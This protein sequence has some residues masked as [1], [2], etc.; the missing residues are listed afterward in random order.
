VNLTVS[1]SSPLINLAR[2]QR[3]DLLRRF[4]GEVIIPS[5]VYE[6]VVT[7]GSDRDGAKDVRAA[8]WIQ[9]VETKD[10]LAVDAL[11]AELDRGE[12]AAIILSR[13]LNANLLLI[14]EIRGRRIA[15]RL[16]IHVTGTIGILTRAKRENLVSSVKDELDKLRQRGTWIDERLYL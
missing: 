7:R 3:F 16:G 12:A 9:Q 10:T 5:A 2:I 6:E 15:E 13:E 4:Y 1:N 11:S 14:D 8:P